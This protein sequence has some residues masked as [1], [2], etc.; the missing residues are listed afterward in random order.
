MISGSGNPYFCPE[1]G[2]FCSLSYTCQSCEIHYSVVDGAGWVPKHCPCFIPPSMIAIW[3]NKISRVKQL[4]QKVVF[5]AFFPTRTSN[6]LD[7]LIF[8]LC[9]EEKAQTSQEMAKLFSEKMKAQK[10]CNNRLRKVLKHS[11]C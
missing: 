5:L 7:Y 10:Q 4:F 6:D 3:I 11:D 1:P 2:G 8:P 9:K